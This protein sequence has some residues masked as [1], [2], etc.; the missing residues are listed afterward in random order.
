WEPRMARLGQVPG[1]G[2]IRWL[3]QAVG[4]RARP[5]RFR[6][7]SKLARVIDLPPDERYLYSFLGCMTEA[8]KDRL[9][10]DEARHQFAAV[11]H[12]LTVLSQYYQRV[13]HLSGLSRRQYGDL[14]NTLPGEMLFKTDSMT[15][16]ANLEARPPLIDH[17][18]VEFAARLPDHLR[19]GRN[20]G[21]VLLKQFAETLIPRD[22]VYRNKHG[23]EVPLDAWFRGDLAG[24]A[25]EVLLSRAARDRGLFE[26]RAV[27][28]LLAAH[29]TGVV[30][31]GIRIYVLLMLELWCQENLDRGAA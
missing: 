2:L 27:E 8:E 6:Q 9:Y 3:D 11:P 22:L 13:P 23:F 21:K 25:R 30:Q 28:A 1:W 14:M 19:A 15:M 29:A 10:T 5:R 17:Q 20:V 7:V 16:A 12:P 31:A 4:M 26:P 24:P 18:V